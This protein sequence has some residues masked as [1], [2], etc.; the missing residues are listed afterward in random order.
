MA[1]FFF[2]VSWAGKEHMSTRYDECLMLLEDYDEEV[3]LFPIQIS[4]FIMLL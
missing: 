4:K 1:D 2:A 3:R